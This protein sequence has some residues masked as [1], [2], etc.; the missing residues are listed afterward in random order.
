MAVTGVHFLQS[1]CSEAQ[2][3][4]T[5]YSAQW[6]VTTDSRTDSATTVRA[7][8]G[9]P[10]RGDI[11]TD[12]TATDPYASC[13]SRTCRLSD[14]NET[15][16]KWIVDLEYS[17]AGSSDNPD[18]NNQNP[19]DPI[20]WS[21]KVS[22]DGWQSMEAP[23][24]DRNGRA[25]VNVVNEPFLPPPEREKQQPL[26]LLTKNHRTLDLSA[27]SSCQG[28]VNSN[29]Q[30]GLTSRKVK[31]RKW[32]FEQRWIG[33]GEMYFANRLEV[34]VKFAGF[35]FQPPNLGTRELVGI[36]LDGTGDYRTL[37]DDDG[38]PYSCPMPL[39]QFG[40]QLLVGMPTQFFDQAAGALQKFELEDEYDFTNILPPVLPGNFITP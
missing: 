8:P 16:K 24:F 32:S 28:K 7:A 2:D 12:G 22:G 25:L 37:V 1:T 9:L 11:F 27:W 34:E 31:L 21:W 29:T 38:Y 17:S 26:I 13:R 33:N 20:D 30:W 6:L 15:M 3:G 23:E 4:T 36:N 40:A 39:D 5:T 19:S 10:K 18:N 35:Y 14:V